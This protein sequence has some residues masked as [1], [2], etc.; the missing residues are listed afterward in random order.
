MTRAAW[1][2][3]SITALALGAA[4]VVGVFL[5]RGSEP[6]DSLVV[7]TPSSPTQS[8]SLPLTNDPSVLA[9]AGRTGNVLVGVATRPGGPVEVAALRAE[10]PIPTQELRM[11]IDGRT[12][13]ARPCGT[14]CSRIETAVL[15]GS[16]R[17]LTVQAGSSRLSF[18]LPA[19]LPPSGAPVFARA[20]RTMDSLHS[21]RFSERLTSGRGGVTTAF[22]VQAPNRLRFRT[23]DGFRSVIIG[24]TRWDYRGGRWERGPFPGLTLPQLLMWNQAGHTRIVGRRP[25]GVT[26]LAAFGVQP[27]PAWFRVAVAPT[28]LVVDAEMI[29]PSHFMTHRYSD[30][31]KR[32]TIKPPR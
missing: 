30:F 3:L 8:F 25:N 2:S 13:D 5:A 1:I 6:A 26:E 31:N 27:V 20:Q 28:G 11:R 17:R 18:D 24:K 32:F 9:V 23:D 14:G 22:D 29:A 4:V 16:P 10:T 21:F 12:V 7:P 19:R 15:D